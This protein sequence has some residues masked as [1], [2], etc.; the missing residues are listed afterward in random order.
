MGEGTRWSKVTCGPGPGFGSRQLAGALL[1]LCPSCT[2]G[3]GLGT[4]SA[5][6]LPAEKGRVSHSS[7][8]RGLSR[9]TNMGVQISF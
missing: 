1:V 5:A 2:G 6:Q 8:G 3:E 4:I 7:W 9:A